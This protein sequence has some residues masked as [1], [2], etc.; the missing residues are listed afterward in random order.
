MKKLTRTEIFAMVLGAIIGMGSFTL[1]GSKFLPS[2]GVIN[3]TIG[4]FIGTMFMVVIERCYRYMM[5]QQIT[6][7]GEFSFTLKFMGRKHGFVVGWFLFLAYITLIPL[8]ALAFPIVVNFLF[9]ELLNFGYL[10]TIAGDDIYIGEVLVA[11][12]LIV[13]FSV[14]NLIGIKNTGKVQKVIVG[15]L[16]VSVFTVLAFML[17]N[18][19]FATFSANYIHTYN[20]NI[21]EIIEIIAVTPFLFIGFDVVPQLI[22]DIGVSSNKASTISATALL[23]GMSI[24]IILNFITALGFSAQQAV[25]M[26]W[27]LGSAVV[28]IVGDW[29]FVLIVAGLGGAVTAGINGF[30]V[31][32]TKL[33]GS[34]GDEKVMP[35]IFGVLNGV[36]VAK[37]TIYFIAAIGILLTFFGRNAIIWVVDMCSFGAA[38]TYLYV[39]I[40]TAKQA[41][42]TSI[43]IFGYAG[44]AISVSIALLLL[45]PMSPARLG[46]EPLII[47]AIWVLLGLVIG[48]KVIKGNKTAKIADGIGNNKII[49]NE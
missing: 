40:I 41:K 20:F 22:N 48:Y 5:S 24:Y 28:N 13:L 9:P 29:A 49:E 44:V 33:I 46:T 2:A 23:F 7:G 10:Y 1:P 8:N 11:T 14:I 17:I 38:I 19:D 37:Y 15:C 16:V 12:S 31:S 18:A 36:G 3:T 6:S 35:G 32:S 30:M 4:L 43:K 39:C 26:E 42:V 45:L 34:M 27:A 25:G 21:S 47:L